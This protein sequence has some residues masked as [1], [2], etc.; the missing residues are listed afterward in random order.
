MR[1]VFDLV[2]FR[3]SIQTPVGATEDAADKALEF[4]SDLDLGAVIDDA[5]FDEI[6][7]W[8]TSGMPIEVEVVM[9]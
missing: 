2:A 3:V 9:T 1:D 6:E 7:R 5:V 4:V 8:N